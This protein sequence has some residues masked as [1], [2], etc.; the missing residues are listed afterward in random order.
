MSQVY[1]NWCSRMQKNH[2][3]VEHESWSLNHSKETWFLTNKKILRDST[4]SIAQTIIERLWDMFF[5]RE[6][7]S[8]MKLKDLICELMKFESALFKFWIRQSFQTLMNIKIITAI[9]VIEYLWAKFINICTFMKNDRSRIRT[10]TIHVAKFCRSRMSYSFNSIARRLS[11]TEVVTCKIIVSR[12]LNTLF[13]RLMIQ[14]QVWNSEIYE[15][16]RL[17]A[18]HRLLKFCNV[19]MKISASTQ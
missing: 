9:R 5:E 10:V 4:L 18:S 13:I 11:T 12:W 19:I 2:L 1:L 6:L 14:R 7:K 16:V 8:L 17:L 3:E 15:L